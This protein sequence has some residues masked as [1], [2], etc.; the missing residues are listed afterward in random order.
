MNDLEKL[1]EHAP[2]GAVA[3]KRTKLGKMFFVDGAG[4]Y[5]HG[6]WKVEFCDKWKTIATRP[7]PETRKTVEDAVEFFKAWPEQKDLVCIWDDRFGDYL[8]LYKGYAP[9]SYCYEVCNYEEFEV[10]VAAK[11]AKSEPE[12]THMYCGERCKI[13]GEQDCFG[14]LVIL[15]ESG[16]YFLDEPS[17][18][19]LIKPPITKAEHEFLCKFSVDVNDIHVTSA[20]ER[21]LAERELKG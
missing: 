1:F 4:R 14:R 21:Y 17:S 5:Y 20:V 19:D 13:Q 6:S 3:I 12:W 8:F 7:Q 18:L 15:T 11:D 10:C 9:V 16:A 2:E